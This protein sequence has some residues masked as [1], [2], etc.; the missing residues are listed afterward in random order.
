MFGG[1][2]R[3]GAIETTHTRAWLRN[4]QQEGRDKFSLQTSILILRNR[5]GTRV[6]RL[7][8]ARR[9]AVWGKPNQT[10]RL[11]CTASFNK[12][13]PSS[14]LMSKR[15]IHLSLLKTPS[16]PFSQSIKA[17]VPRETEDGRLSAVSQIRRQALAVEPMTMRLPI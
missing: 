2:G 7:G 12:K 17:N 13:S 5:A 15:Q 8:R 6:Q 14:D 3:P 1:Y 11:K 10:I 9:E 4:R 16:R